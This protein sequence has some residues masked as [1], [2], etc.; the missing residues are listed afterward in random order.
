MLQE[1]DLA[2]RGSYSSS[3]TLQRSNTLLEDIDRRLLRVSK[4]SFK[5]DFSW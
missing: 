5:G 3:A 2:R 1:T 4:G